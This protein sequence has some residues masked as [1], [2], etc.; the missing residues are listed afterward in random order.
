SRTGGFAAVSS[1][2]FRS[3]D[4]F[5]NGFSN[6]CRRAVKHN[7]SRAPPVPGLV[8]SQSRLARCRPEPAERPGVPSPGGQGDGAM[9]AATRKLMSDYESAFSDLD[10]Q[11]QLDTF[12]DAFMA[13]GPNGTIGQ[14]RKD[15]KEA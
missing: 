8:F 7:D 13:A 6:S 2:T 9:D 3:H 5:T 14:S 11:R 12:G 1:T 10:T 15:F 4:Q